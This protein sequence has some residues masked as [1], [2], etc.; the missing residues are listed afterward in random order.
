VVLV[1]P[2]QMAIVVAKLF[3]EWSLLVEVQAV[4]EPPPQPLQLWAVV[5]VGQEELQ[6]TEI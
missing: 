3:M 2:L 4:L 5:E 1:Y 6:P